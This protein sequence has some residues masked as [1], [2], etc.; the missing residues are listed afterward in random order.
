[1][2]ILREL[3]KE[4]PELITTKGNNYYIDGLGW[5]KQIKNIFGV[6]TYTK[7]IDDNWIRTDFKEIEKTLFSVYR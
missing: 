5:F 7:D 2:E 4:F 1:M 6:N 3:K